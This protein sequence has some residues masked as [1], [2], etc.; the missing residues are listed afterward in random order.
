MNAEELPR[1]ARRVAE[2]L[3]ARGHEGRVVVLEQTARSAEEAAEALGVTP[4]QIVKS[5]VFRGTE[6]DGVVLALLAGD[7]RVDPELLAAAANEPVERPEAAWVRERTGFAIGGVP[8]LGHPSQPLVL[9]DPALAEAGTVWAAAGT[10]HAVFDVAGEQLAELT[11]G[12][13]ARLADNTT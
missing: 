10:P 7:H 13:V 12:T 6:S 9:I 3:A 1:S 4:R 2:A 5:L 8:P 11:G